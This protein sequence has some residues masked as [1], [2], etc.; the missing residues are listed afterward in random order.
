MINNYL[1]K[2]IVILFIIESDNL[3]RVNMIKESFQEFNFCKQIQT[4]RKPKDFL[5][6]FL[7]LENV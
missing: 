3:E 2:Y 6:G 7:E 4:K 1:K 5:M